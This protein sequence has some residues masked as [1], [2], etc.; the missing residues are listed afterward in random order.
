MH[1]TVHPLA[2]LIGAPLLVAWT[3]AVVTL[4]PLVLLALVAITAIEWLL[5]AAGDAM[6]APSAMFADVDGGAA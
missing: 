3:L 4:G 1:P 2:I 6:G 5:D